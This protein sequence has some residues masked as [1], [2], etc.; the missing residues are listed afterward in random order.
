MSDP[1]KLLTGT[2]DDLLIS[3]ASGLQQAQN[4]LGKNVVFDK[5][6]GTAV[7]YTL[8]RL[9]FELKTIV[10]LTDSP[11]IVN[12]YGQSN[13]STKK[14]PRMHI[15]LKPSTSSVAGSLQSES[16]STISGSF[17]AIPV[18][19]GAPTTVVKT[20]LLRNSPTNISVTVLVST[21]LGEPLPGREVHFNIDH[22][23]CTQLNGADVKS[24]THFD[25]GVVPTDGS[26]NATSTLLISNAEVDGIL[27]PIEVGVDGQT[28]VIVHKYST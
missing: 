14:L 7:T 3:I 25:V 18:N 1:S 9:D 15:V 17:V 12:K 21:N 5:Y 11:S 23:L 26:G 27:V 19:N 22:D 8:P 2:I 16:L 13:K 10:Q 24:G 4:E 6:S 28:E 20:S